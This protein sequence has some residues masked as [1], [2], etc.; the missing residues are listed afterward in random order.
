M[1]LNARHWPVNIHCSIV[2]LRFCANVGS[3]KQK[4]RQNG[5]NLDPVNH[6]CERLV[7]KQKHLSRKDPNDN[8]ALQAGIA[9]HQRVIWI[10]FLICKLSFEW[11]FLPSLWKQRRKWRWYLANCQFPIEQ[12]AIQVLGFV[13]SFVFSAFKKHFNWAFSGNIWHLWTSRAPLFHFKTYSQAVGMGADH[14][15]NGHLISWKSTI[16]RRWYDDDWWQGGKAR[17]TWLPFHSFSRAQP[18]PYHRFDRHGR[19]PRWWS[20]SEEAQE[21]EGKCWSFAMNAFVRQLILY[22]TFTISLGWARTEIKKIRMQL[23]SLV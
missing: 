10:F 12:L 22:T 19:I 18:P 20:N 17:M 15:T 16:Q 21:Q 23:N 2:S 11:S 14:V 5:R 4:T 7:V 1:H 9:L 6:R 3:E 8:C 13:L